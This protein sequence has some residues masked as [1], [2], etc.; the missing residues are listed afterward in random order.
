MISS[1]DGGF[2]LINSTSSSGVSGSYNVDTYGS[3][4]I[5]LTKFDSS[6][7]IEWQQSYGGNNF[8]DNGRLIILSDG[9]LLCSH[10]SSSISGNKSIAS[11]GDSDGWMLK[12]D[13]NGNIV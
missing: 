11:F 1:P 2:Y 10:S 4:Y 12:L 5:V 13:F 6:L 3:N 9:L 8:E 7:I